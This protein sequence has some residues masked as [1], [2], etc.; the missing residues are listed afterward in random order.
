MPF[1]GYEFGNQLIKE[2]KLKDVRL[3]KTLI[4]DHY[5]L[6]DKKV[7]VLEDRLRRKVLHQYLSFVMK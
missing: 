2:L 7:K 4:G 3:E 6:N 1:D 5:D